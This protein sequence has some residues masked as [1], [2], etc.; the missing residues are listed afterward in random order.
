MKYEHQINCTKVYTD[1]LDDTVVGQAQK[2]SND[3][4]SIRTSP[5]SE[6]MANSEGCTSY[7]HKNQINSYDFLRII[8][9]DAL[10][11]SVSFKPN[12]VDF[13][14]VIDMLALSA[15][16]H[17]RVCIIVLQFIQTVHTRRG[18]IE[19]NYLDFWFSTFWHVFL[20]FS[21]WS[22]LFHLGDVPFFSRAPKSG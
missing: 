7:D 16:H 1:K 11:L 3:L 21:T 17:R 9:V 19:F 14:L 4:I 10:L 6:R 2:G 5:L 15:I 13:T 8:R 18:T 20:P 22:Q 12:F